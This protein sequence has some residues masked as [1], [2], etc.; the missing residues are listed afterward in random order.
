MS[1]KIKWIASVWFWAVGI[2]FNPFLNLSIHCQAQF[3][4]ASPVLVEV[5]LALS[6]IITTHPPQPT[7]PPG[8]VEMQL[9]MDHIWSVDSYGGRGSLRMAL[10]RGDPPNPGKYIINLK[11]TKY[12]PWKL[13]GWLVCDLGLL[14]LIVITGLYLDSLGVVLDYLG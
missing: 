8:N 5:R 4:L 6:L 12:R 3:Q 7:H 2:V 13:R 14:K 10:E 11:L 9:E 1:L